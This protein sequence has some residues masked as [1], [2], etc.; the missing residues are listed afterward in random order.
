MQDPKPSL[1]VRI[2]VLY[3]VVLEFIRAK[4]PITML[5]V[6]TFTFGYGVKNVEDERERMLSYVQ[7]QDQAQHLKAECD[8][9]LV[10]AE[11]LNTDQTARIADQTG[12]ITE[13]LALITQLQTTVDE[14]HTTQ[15]KSVAQRKAELTTIKKAA[16]EAQTAAT[17]A[18]KGVT[19]KERQQ[20][21]AEVKKGK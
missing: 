8:A 19:E 16:T 15:Q 14:I 10:D 21:N 17:I 3:E 12:R 18:Q 1:R 2:T 11:K 4:L 13:Q 20:I 6:G 5:V 9:R 7:M